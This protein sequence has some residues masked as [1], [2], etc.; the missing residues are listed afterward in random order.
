ME[1]WSSHLQGKYYTTQAPALEIL[2]KV[3]ITH[4]TFT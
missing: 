4:N 1:L 2:M 3:V